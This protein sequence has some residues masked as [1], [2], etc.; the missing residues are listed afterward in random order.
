MNFFGTTMLSTSYRFLAIQMGKGEKGNL[1]KV[2]NTVFIIHVV[3]A[4]FL[5]VVGMLIIFLMLTGRKYQMHYL[6]FIGV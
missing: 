1:N 2:Y 6:F 4:I 3:L 5:L